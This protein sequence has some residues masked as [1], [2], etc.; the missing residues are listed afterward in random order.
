MD[1]SEIS[2]SDSEFWLEL[3]KQLVILDKN[4][5]VSEIK[6][7]KSALKDSEEEFLKNAPNAYYRERLQQLVSQVRIA[8]QTN[9]QNKIA[10]AIS[11]LKNEHKQAIREINAVH[12]EQIKTLKKEFLIL[13]RTLKEKDQEIAVLSGKLVEQE[14]FVT[15]LRFT[16]TSK[17]YEEERKIADL[18][19][20]LE[21]VRFGFNMQ[22]GHMKELVGLYKRDEE[23]AKEGLKN[24]ENELMEKSAEYEGKILSL[25]QEMQA[26]RKE[27]EEKI[28]SINEKYEAFR[29]DIEK[30]LSIR[31]VINKR[32]Q[33]FI[34]FLKNELKN[35]KMIIETPRLNARY[36]K[37]IGKR[38]FSLAPAI[39]ESAEIHMKKFKS[40]GLYK[41]NMTI[42]SSFSTSASPMY[43]NPSELDL[44]FSSKLGLV[45]ESKYH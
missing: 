30:E 11:I 19:S 21:A 35:A 32:Q 6:L 3:D 38:G 4:P 14:G 36:L 45:P 27:C 34:D 24:M 31:H 18:T 5:K 41:K 2:D 28:S 42:N 23:A 22:M 39:E 8:G 25:S 40:K 33:V 26:V 17:N 9:F 44:I 7:E 12:V 13:E 29:A 20:S 1:K 37:K 43:S 16:K 15:L 10:K